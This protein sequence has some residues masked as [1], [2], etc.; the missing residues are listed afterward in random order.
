M[1]SGRKPRTGLRADRRAHLPAP[2]QLLEY[3][4]VREC[5]GSAR[6]GWWPAL[7][8]TG[9]HWPGALWPGG[10]AG[11]QDGTTGAQ[12]MRVQMGRSP[13]GSVAYRGDW[14]SVVAYPQESSF[15]R[16]L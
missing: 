13:Q 3:G 8:W 7:R 5:G 14:S 15:R 4:R 11:V 9:A 1:D 10:I 12:G 6:A 16:H 2:A